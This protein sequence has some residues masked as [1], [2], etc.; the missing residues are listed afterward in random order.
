M[1]LG[2][3]KIT[4]EAYAKIQEMSTALGIG[5]YKIRVRVI[6]GGCAGFSY[7]MAFEE[8]STDMD[9]LI[10][11]NDVTIIVDQLSLQYLDGTE[12]D[13]EEQLLSGGFKFNNPNVTSNCGCGSSFSV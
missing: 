5:H 10:V 12:I 6:G 1:R 4:N 8:V 9:E 7:D 13:Y 3:I 2:M 11:I